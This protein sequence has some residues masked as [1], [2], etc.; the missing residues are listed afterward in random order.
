MNQRHHVQC[1]DRILSLDNAVVMG[2]L[3][4]TPDS[5]S[6]G[7]AMF[8]AGKLDVPLLQDKAAKM[9]EDGAKILDIGGESTRPGAPFVSLQEELDRV[10]PALEALGGKTEAVISIDTSR[11]EVILEA[12][13]LG[14]GIINDVRGLTQEG[15][16][17]AAVST[18]LGVCL[19]HMQG[20][21]D[22]MQDNPSYQNVISEVNDFLNDRVEACLGSG[23]DQNRLMI[24]PGFG[25]GKKL[26]N[27]LHLLAHLSEIKVLDCPVL[28]GMSRKSM[29]GKV[30]NNEPHERLAGSLAAAVLAVN[31]GAKIV[32]A[33]DVKATYDAITITNAVI[34]E[35]RE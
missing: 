29:I 18:R 11:P 27:N 8:S 25:F 4:V 30:L 24:D 22:T 3:N 19:M 20:Q 33:H 7:G 5:F 9:V 15:A 26:D 12:A 10:M 13:R 32:R 35:V 23:V 17:Q 31:N 2:V 14:A 21:P 16:L 28:V 34:K 1:G 6:D